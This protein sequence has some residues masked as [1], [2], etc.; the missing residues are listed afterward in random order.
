ML[1]SNDFEGHHA[2]DVGLVEARHH[3]SWAE[4][5]LAKEDL[6]GQ[7]AVREAL[8]PAR[9]LGLVLLQV[10]KRHNIGLLATHF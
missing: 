5:Q 3:F 2:F 7:V 4:N 6:L 1:M 8:Q 9:R 10:A